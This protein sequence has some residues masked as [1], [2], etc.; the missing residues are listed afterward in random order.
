MLLGNTANIEAADSTALTEELLRYIDYRGRMGTPPGPPGTAPPLAASM[1]WPLVKRV[2]IR[3]NCA[4][5]A[6]G[7]ILIDLPGI[8]DSN[9]ARNS[10][11]QNYL[12]RADR[13]F[14]VAP[15]AR[16][17]SERTTNGKS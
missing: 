12:R 6:C 9:A 15:I 1:Y 13:V 17:V 16:V 11:T 14:I 2:R 10:I 5:L 4:L 3:V 7:A 8:G